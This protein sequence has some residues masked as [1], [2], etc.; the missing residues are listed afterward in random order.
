MGAFRTRSYFA[1]N[2][3]MVI[4]VQKK[5]TPQQS[6]VSPFLYPV[7]LFQSAFWLSL[8]HWPVVDALLA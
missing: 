4:G 1:V 3:V 8:H 5:T 7:G 6:K 2:T